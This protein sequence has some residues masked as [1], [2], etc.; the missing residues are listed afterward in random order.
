M[1]FRVMGV[2]HWGIRCRNPA[3]SI[4][5]RTKPQAQS[6]YGNIADVVL[7]F[8]VNK[9]IYSKSLLRKSFYAYHDEYSEVGFCTLLS[10]DG[11]I[12]KSLGVKSR[13][14]TGHSIARL[15][16]IH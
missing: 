6:L 11:P 12:K 16:P 1:L 8:F 9:G 3:I 5:T 15:L 4:V 14:L 13:D 10:L 7:T 2:R